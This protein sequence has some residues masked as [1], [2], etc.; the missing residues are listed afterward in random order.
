MIPRYGEWEKLFAE[1]GLRVVGVHTGEFDYER[2]D[3]K[4]AEFVK[5]QDI[6]WPVVLDP[7]YAAWSRFDIKAWP[8]VLLIDRAGIIRGSYVGD[9]RAPEIERDL[10]ALLTH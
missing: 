2:D 7:D 8:T 10:R 9:D 3:K 1:K 4:V 5:K 6:H